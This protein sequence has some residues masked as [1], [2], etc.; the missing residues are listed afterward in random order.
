MEQTLPR[1]ELA[2]NDR[3]VGMVYDMLLED[4]SRLSAYDGHSS[5]GYEVVHSD[6]KGKIGSVSFSPEREDGKL[7]IEGDIL[8]IRA[9]AEKIKLADGLPSPLREVY[10]AILDSLEV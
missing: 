9:R 3:N 1:W 7:E 4:G 8:G 2:E 10:I 6:R 5:R